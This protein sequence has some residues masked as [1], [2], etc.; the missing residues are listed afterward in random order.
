MENNFLSKDKRN[1]KELIKNLSIVLNV[2]ISTL[3]PI[4]EKLDKIILKSSLKDMLEEFFNLL[5]TDMSSLIDKRITP[6]FQ[7]GLRNKYFTFIGYYGKYNSHTTSKDITHNTY[8]SFDSISKVLTSIVTMLMIRDGKVTF[9]SPVTSINPEFNMDASIESILKFTAMIQTE[10]RIDNLPISETIDILKRCKENLQEKA[11]YKNYYQYND[12]GYMILRLSIPDFLDRLDTILNLIDGDNLT[13]KNT[14]FKDKITGGRL[15]LEYFTPDT[16]GRGIDFPGHT[17]LYGNIEGLLNLFYQIFFTNNILTKEE[18]EIL[19]KVPYNDPSVYTKDG[20]RAVS[21]NGS[22][23]YMAKTSGIYRTPTNMLEE[24]INKMT[25]C[26]FSNLTTNRAMASAG[27]CGS[28]VMGDNIAYNALFGTYTGGILTN[29]YSSIEIGNY[30][31]SRNMIPGT[32]L[33]VNQRGVI[34]NYSSMLNEYK[35][36]ICQYGLILEVLTEYIKNTYK[37]YNLDNKQITYIRKLKPN[38]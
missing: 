21:K 29:P 34:F 1:I 24:K 15:G 18:L 20:T 27:T 7:F 33:V 6:S 23:Q 32:N 28:W 12:I 5:E 13:Y 26:D 35:E 4:E 38:R 10:K 11:L 25:S 22:M 16:K 2:D 8:Y 36:I 31:D 14:S 30:P 19:L 37:D 9:N 17:G 3:R